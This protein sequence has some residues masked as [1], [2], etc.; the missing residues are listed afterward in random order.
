LYRFGNGGNK[1]FVFV[2]VFVT[3]IVPIWG[4]CCVRKFE[5]KIEFQCDAKALP[6]AF[7]IRV[8]LF[9][10]SETTSTEM[11]DLD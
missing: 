8:I 11:L 9:P 2:F 5:G 7:M 3:G 1:L 6:G 4:P 10:A